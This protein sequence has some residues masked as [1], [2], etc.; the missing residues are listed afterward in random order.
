M[1]TV[2]AEYKSL[3][4]YIDIINEAINKI[5]KPEIITQATLEDFSPLENNPVN[6]TINAE[7]FYAVDKKTLSEILSPPV[8]FK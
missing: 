6:I 7:N 1:K 8:V 4:S 3:I 5:K 2:I